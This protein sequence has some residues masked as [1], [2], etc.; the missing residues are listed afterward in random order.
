[1]EIRLHYVNGIYEP[2]HP[3][4]QLELKARL[5]A[6]LESKREEADDH[7]DA[8][9][10]PDENVGVNRSEEPICITFFGITIEDL[11]YYLLLL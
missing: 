7:F 9:Y 5:T 2:I 4:N 1:M 8:L 10:F 3:A 6:V 11:L